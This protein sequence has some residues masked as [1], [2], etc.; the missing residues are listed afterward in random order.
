MGGSAETQTSEMLRN[1]KI[2]STLALSGVACGQMEEM[3]ALAK[4]IGESKDAL[5][6][7]EI[8]EVVSL[9]LGE[10]VVEHE[11]ETYDG[12]YFKAPD[13]GEGEDFSWYFNAPEDW[14]NWYVLP[15]EEDVK[16][17]FRDWLNG[18]MV[19]ERFDRAGEKNRFRVLQT[20]SGS[21]FEAGKEY[22]LWFRQIKDAEPGELRLKA[23]FANPEKGENWDYEKLEK[24]LNLKPKDSAAQIAELDSL[25]G[26]ILLDGKFFDPQYADGR[27]DSLFFAKR[28][29]KQM[30]GG[31]FI[32]ISTST[33][34]CRTEPK[35][36]DIIAK[37]GEP[38]FVRSSEED[39]RRTGNEEVDEGDE[40]TVTYY[41]D[42]FGFV[43][44][45]GDEEKIVRQV[46]AQAN[47]FSGLRPEGE[48]RSTFGQ[49]GFENLTVFHTDGKEVGRIYR[50]DEEGKQ[51]L[52]VKA[53]PE[54]A[55]QNGP[56][57]LSF[58][59][60][61][62]W[63]MEGVSETGKRI[64]T[65]RYVQDRLNGLTEVFH[66]N[67]KLKLSLT[68]KDGVPDGKF[69]EFDE[70]GGVVREAIYKD[71]VPVE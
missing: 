70:E 16:L 69:T 41:Y 25:G 23:T 4:A 49:L 66:E 15:L 47:D 35:L 65:K 33:P 57:T 60:E 59:G 37:Y 6:E 22:V 26:R 9:T 34:P 11:G 18:D 24:A 17:G 43:A 62:T 8:G 63:T 1:L 3:Q 54:G 27:I 56:V 19:Y 7:I 5:T 2:L 38:D 21:Y 10:S 48:A 32:Q 71:G 45:E 50:F 58:L 67:G 61:G 39:S 51:P 12:V 44:E 68:Y 46:T 64:Y 55:Y 30:S 31:F 53:P 52:V 40:S 20:L 42:Y 14:A 13:K 29:Q 28:Q 36:A